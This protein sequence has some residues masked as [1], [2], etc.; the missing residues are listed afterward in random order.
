MEVRETWGFFFFGEKGQQI[1][2][3]DR[4]TNEEVIK[5]VPGQQKLV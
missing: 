4:E 1:S 5:E 3:A 2:R